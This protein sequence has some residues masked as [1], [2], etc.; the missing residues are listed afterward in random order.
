MAKWQLIAYSFLVLWIDPKP[1]THQPVHCTMFSEWEQATDEY[2]VLDLYSKDSSHQH[3][4]YLLKDSLNSPLLYYAS[5]NTP[6]CIDELCKPLVVSVYWNLLGNYAGYGLV[7]EEPLSKF[8]HEYFNQAD[9]RKLHELL[10][11]DN[12]ILERRKL[13]QLYDSQVERERKITYKGVEVD[14]ITAA[15]KKEIKT[16]VV[17][18]ALYSCYTLWH[19]AHGPVKTQ[20]MERITQLF[21][22]DQMHRWLYSEYIDYQEYALKKLQAEAFQQHADRIIEL[23]KSS[24]PATRNYLLK[25][26][27]V[28]FWSEKETSTAIYE[29]FK[30]LDVNS[31]TVLI[32]KLNLAPDL[33]I[34]LLSPSVMSMTKNQLKGFL[35]V[36]SLSMLHADPQVIDHLRVV[37][38]QY[39]F[40]YL[41]EAYLNRE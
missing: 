37:S 7:G 17:E 6:V 11:D 24:R 39:P 27:P 34:R 33:A 10:L 35:E 26:L 25:K 3:K 13:E 30:D 14:A 18:G 23:I 32:Q 22:P 41:I 19:L 8:D 21:E 15:T 36:L 9:Y 1:P 40:V 2:H 31:R 4:V 28:T 20:I 29:S 5:I 16:T 38:D 12:S